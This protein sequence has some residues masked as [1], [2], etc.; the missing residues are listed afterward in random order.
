MKKII[1]LPKTITTHLFGANHS[2]IHRIC[3]GLVVAGSGISLA[4]AS[5][6]FIQPVRFLVDFC[7]MSLHGIGIVPII[8][9]MSLHE[10]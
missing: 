10:E 1:L 3:V 6:L 9:R 4:Y 2:H 7:G 5:T 8:E